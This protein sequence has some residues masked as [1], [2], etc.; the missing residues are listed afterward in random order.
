VV[1]LGNTALQTV[2]RS[3]TQL[4]ATVPA[5]LVAEGGAVDVRVGN[6]RGELSSTA[7]LLI[8][9]DPPK[10]T[11]ITPQ[12]TGTG[13]DNLE[14]TITGERFQRG[15]AVLVQ[16]AAVPTTFVSSTTL[17]AV[18]PTTFFARAADLP[19]LVVNADGN[20]S[21]ALMLTVENGPL[22]TRLSRG[23]IKAGIGVFELTVGGVAFKPGVVLFANETALST[24]FV[25]EASFT[26]R[27]PAAM[28]AQPGVL[29]LQARHPDGG[30]SNTVK[31]KV[32][33]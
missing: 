27:I 1:L 19:L 30:R 8:V 17:I 12:S 9:D 15:A 32:I 23:K 31:L 21:N 14:V 3:D 5:G 7:R 33:Q 29:T 11:K 20:Q 28:T 16:G 24:T 2:F 22:I 13:A 18:V 25:S 4:E 6:P 10:I 26:A